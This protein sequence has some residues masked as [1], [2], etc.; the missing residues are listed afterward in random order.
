MTELRPLV[1]GAALRHRASADDRLRPAGAVEVPIV[2]VGGSP[3]GA[4]QV[5]GSAADIAVDESRRPVLAHM[6]LLQEWMLCG[7]ALSGDGN[8]EAPTFA[9]LITTGA[10]QIAYLETGA[11]IALE[12]THHW[13]SPMVRQTRRSRCRSARRATR[14]ASTSSGARPHETKL[15][16]ATGD[17]ISTATATVGNTGVTRATRLPSSPTARLCGTSSRRRVARTRRALS[18]T[19]RCNCNSR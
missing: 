17:Q 14:A 13:W 5:D 18:W 6:R 12:A 3:T 11:N 15:A 1:D 16:A 2:F 9:G 19:I 10:E 4:W 7:C 8:G